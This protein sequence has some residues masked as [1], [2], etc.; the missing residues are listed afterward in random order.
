MPTHI[1]VSSAHLL[2]ELDAEMHG[3]R[4]RLARLAEGVIPV[5]RDAAAAIGL[6]LRDALLEDGGPLNEEF[7]LREFLVA[8]GDG[9]VPAGVFD[10][11]EVRIAMTEVSSRVAR[12]L[13]A[14]VAAG[15]AE[16][17]V[18]TLACLAQAPSRAEDGDL[19]LLSE[20]LQAPTLDYILPVVLVGTV[21]VLDLA[22]ERLLARLQD[23]DARLERALRQVLVPIEVSTLRGCGPLEG[24]DDIPDALDGAGGGERAASAADGRQAAREDDAALLRHMPS[25]DVPFLLQVLRQEEQDGEESHTFE[26]LARRIDEVRALQR[27]A[28]EGSRG[29]QFAYVRG[30]VL[31][32]TPGVVYAGFKTIDQLGADAAA[33]DEPR[34]QSGAALG[35]WWERWYS[36]AYL[37]T[38]T[39][40][41]R[42]G[43]DV[44]PFS[45]LDWAKAV[46]AMKAVTAGAR[47]ADGFVPGA[48]A[49]LPLDGVLVEPSAHALAPDAASRKGARVLFRLVPGSLPPAG[50]GGTGGAGANG[51]NG[52][53]RASGAT[54]VTGD[55]VVLCAVLRTVD[56]DG[57]GLSQYNVYATLPAAEDALERHTAQLAREAGLEVDAGYARL[58]VC[59][60]HLRLEV[61]EAIEAP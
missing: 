26:D 21:P 2:A 49:H 11:P 53:N 9:L 52:V 4:V 19:A 5:G 17:G 25:E 60:R 55:L 28:S 31:V 59:G 48:G 58:A 23:G 46:T 47:D 10:D 50:P 30:V 7:V 3:I 51:S 56:A 34:F 33:H 16:D 12:V 1:S 36:H 13:T 6:A 39:T 54:R 44:Q 32:V 24:L 15:R 18:A 14:E 20:V 45:Q 8:I 27:I 22:A 38:V 29:P 61:G 35:A 37:P 40:L 41:R 43:F 42:A 57:R